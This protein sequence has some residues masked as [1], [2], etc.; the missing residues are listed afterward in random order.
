MRAFSMLVSAVASG[1]VVLL[2]G[3]AGGSGTTPGSAS[4]P[5]ETQSAVRPA[6]QHQTGVAPQFLNLIHFGNTV[7]NVRPAKGGIPKELAVSD[8]GTNAVE[9]LN[10][11]YALTSTIT[12][13]ITSA[14]GDALDSKG[15]LYVANYEGPNVVEYAKGGTSPSF[16]YSAGLVNPI[17][18][19]I[20]SKD[21]L[22]VA[23]HGLGNPSS[24]FEYAQGSNTIVNQC[25]PGGP[26]EGVIVD[27]QG[28]VFISYANSS[29]VGALAEYKGGLAGCNETILKPT[30]EAGGG[31]AFDKKG[32]LLACDQIVGV[33][34]IPPPYTSISSTITGFSDTFHIALNKKGNL[35]YVAD[36]G[37]AD[38]AVVSY[39][40]GT[41]IT[42]LGAANGLSDPAGVA[43]YPVSKK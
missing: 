42:T 30:L 24:V 15:N 8:F 6:A 4:L 35:L 36:P 29:G 26:L 1:T 22:Y 16:T 39:P 37:N 40:S 2:A 28:D 11:S 5:S 10:S 12:T 27:P 14:D 18:V 13:G 25:S 32:N 21:N 20:D 38:V 7:L 19:A 3:C 34:I 43:A 9:I 23:D 31:L 33:D 17:D 41:L